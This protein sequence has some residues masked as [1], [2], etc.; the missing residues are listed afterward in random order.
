MIS[1][2]GTVSLANTDVDSTKHIGEGGHF[3]RTELLDEQFFSAQT[4]KETIAAGSDAP[5]DEDAGAS[6]TE[7]TEADL[8][9]RSD[10]LRG[11]SAQSCRLILLCYADDW[12]IVHFQSTPKVSTYLIA[13]ANGA[14]E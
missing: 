11:H 7:Q 3:L 5:S 4:A 14:F 1:R 12:E 6:A 10:T 8:K 9:G 13:F 2:T